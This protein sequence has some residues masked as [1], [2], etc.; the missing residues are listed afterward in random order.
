MCCFFLYARGV[1]LVDRSSKYV[2]SQRPKKDGGE[3]LALAAI[4]ARS[5]ADSATTARVNTDAVL[6]VFSVRASAA[7]RSFK[8]EVAHGTAVFA[9]AAGASARPVL[10]I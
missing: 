7:G 1:S 4:P 5:D 3:S 6:E 9:D 8:R 2:F 10:L